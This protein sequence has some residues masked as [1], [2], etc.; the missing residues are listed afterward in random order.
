VHGLYSS[1][2]LPPLIFVLDF[3]QSIRHLAYLPNI[4]KTWLTQGRLS[5]EAIFTIWSDEG[6]MSLNYIKTK[7]AILFLTFFC[8][9]QFHTVYAMETITSENMK[10]Y[11][12]DLGLIEVDP[13][14]YT[15]KDKDLLVFKDSQKITH[16]IGGREHGKILAIKN[17]SGKNK[18]NCIKSYKGSL[19]PLSFYSDGPGMSSGRRQPKSELINLSQDKTLAEQLENAGFRKKADHLYFY[20]NSAYHTYILLEER[21]NGLLFRPSSW[22]LQ[23]QEGP[24][25]LVS[26]QP[27]EQETWNGTQKG[28][29][30]E[31]SHENGN[32]I[33]VSAMG[34]CTYFK[35]VKPS[36]I[37]SDFSEVEEKLKK[38]SQIEL[39]QI[40]AIPPQN[41]EGFRDLEARMRP[42]GLGPTED[43]YLGREESLSSILKEDNDY[44]QTLGL[45]HY[46][47]AQPLLDL[48][49]AHNQND[50]TIFQWGNVKS[51]LEV[52]HDGSSIG[53]GYVKFTWHG[54]LYIFG[55]VQHK[56]DINS[57]FALID[58]EHPIMARS[59]YVI[60]NLDNKEVLNFSEMSGE[61]IRRYGF[62]EGKGAGRYRTEP[63]QI[64]KVF[65]WLNL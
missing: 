18:L 60:Q 63:S 55:Y 10:K 56:S 24:M 54:T 2:P 29:R 58:K 32:L 51:D 15:S 50:A 61:M 16:V 36:W 12:P 13:G 34:D 14:I 3:S 35:V 41:S 39:H 43:F 40:V 20:P 62:Y 31:F 44:V 49:A 9:F 8:L 21:N 11:Q 42:K 33:Q 5:G 22:E 27:F 59:N 26:F 38:Y 28:V 52:I 37:F 46:Q 19:V 1:T 30:Y 25:R 57:P 6:C 45:S 7:M 23:L 48:V 47:V 4:N 64:L 65:P 53:R 17:N